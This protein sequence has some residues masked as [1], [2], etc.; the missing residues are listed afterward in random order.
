MIIKSQKG[1]TLVEAIIA[2]A[3][4]VAIA[5]GIVI[6]VITALSGAT[7]NQASN[8]ALNY[9]Q[10]GSDLVKD[11]ASNNFTAFHALP[12]TNYYCFDAEATTLIADSN[13]PDYNYDPT[14][15]PDSSTN[16]SGQDTNYL[17]KI[18]INQSGCD[19]RKGS[20][21][22]VCASGTVFV[23]SIVSWSDAKCKSTSPNCHKVEIDSCLTDV[24]KIPTP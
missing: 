13:D 16:I 7:S 24:N 5:T 20:C 3:V 18:Y 6:A 9:A 2:L 23:A 8:F 22:Q 10:E 14:K 4:A 17:R 21:S 15:C 1:E 11:Q 19:S 12:D